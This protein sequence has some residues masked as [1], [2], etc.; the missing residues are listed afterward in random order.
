MRDNLL[1]GLWLNGLD[2]YQD[3]VISL[4]FTQDRNIHSIPFIINL[5]FFIFIVITAS[6]WYG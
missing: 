3:N 6:I 4:P 1:A 5:I 2:N